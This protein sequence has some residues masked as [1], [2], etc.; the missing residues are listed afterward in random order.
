[1]GWATRQQ[2]AFNAATRH[3]GGVSITAGAVSGVGMFDLPGVAVMDGQ[4][5]STAYTLTCRTSEFGD[6]GYGASITVDGDAYLVQEPMTIGDGAFVQLTMER[7]SG[8]PP[9]VPGATDI[10]IELDGDLE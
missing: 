7:V 10:E 6:L 1:M 9:W 5:I 3:L 8:A 4:V 2:V